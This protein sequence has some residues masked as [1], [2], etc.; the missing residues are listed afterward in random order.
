[1]S[2]KDHSISLRKTAA[3]VLSLAIS[4]GAA[5]GQANQQQQAKSGQD[6][7]LMAAANTPAPVPAAKAGASAKSDTD[8][9]AEELSE[10]RSVLDSQSAQLK[11][12]QQQIQALESQLKKPDGAAA[13]APATVAA[14]TTG[15]STKLDIP[16]P[17]PGDLVASAARPASPAPTPAPAP[18]AAST[19]APLQFKLGSAFFTPVGFMDFTG[20]YRNH[21]SGGGIGSSFGSIPYDLSSPTNINLLNHASEARLSMQNSRIGLRVDALVKGA[22]VIGYLETDFLGST[23]SSTDANL[24]VSSN[25]NYLRSR[26]YWVDLT[27]DKWELLGGQTW[28][29][30]TPGRSG[31]SPLPGNVFFTNN[32]DVNYQAGLPWGRIPELRFVYH[33]SGKMAFAVAL[34]NQEQYFGGSSGDAKPL[35]PTGASVVAGVSTLPGTQLNDGTTQ[36]NGP[37]LFPD[38]IVKFAFDPSPKFHGEFGGV[39]RQFRVTVNS[40][41]SAASDPIKQSLTGGGAFFNLNGQVIPGLRLLT[42]NFWNEGGGRYIYGQVPDVIVNPDGSLLPVR[43]MSTVSGFELTHKNT[44]FYA[45]YGGIYVR[46]TLGIANGNEYGYGVTATAA[47]FATAIAQNRTIQEATFGFNQTLWRDTKYGALNFMGQYSYLSRIPGQCPRE[48]RPKRPSTLF[49]LTCAIRCLVQPRQP[50]P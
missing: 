5:F 30:I 29:L 33:P 21:N 9:L 2:L 27:K 49:S 10:L 15:S 18:Q 39:E 7:T 3:I 26:L 20:V 43:S 23:S 16:K 31:I 14:P 41:T 40:T 13:P 42:N 50:R 1:M 17:V 28:S 25:S 36:N 46:K 44:L 24:A 45:Y 8:L 19:D 32:I 12:Q 11:E 34:D 6:A 47:N 37:Q 35:L 38:L 22:H 48:I 4:A